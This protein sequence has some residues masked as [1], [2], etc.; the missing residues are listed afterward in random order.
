MQRVSDITFRLVNI[1][2]LCYLISLFLY[3]KPG[4]PIEPWQVNPIAFYLLEFVSFFVFFLFT[5]KYH[6]DVKTWVAKIAIIGLSFMLYILTGEFLLV[7]YFWLTMLQKILNYKRLSPEEQPTMIRSVVNNSML[8]VIA[9]FC[10]IPLGL[11]YLLFAIIFM[12]HTILIGQQATN[13]TYV[14]KTD[15]SYIA[16]YLV[17]YFILQIIRELM[18][19]FNIKLRPFG[20]KHSSHSLPISEHTVDLR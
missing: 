12:P 15:P 7:I 20:K 1:A 18:A 16:L 11:G 2:W 8:F 13:A 3:V 6:H 10:I 17:L 5:E 9:P 4:V 19:I 14:A